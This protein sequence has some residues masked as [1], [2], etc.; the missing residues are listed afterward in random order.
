[1][2]P[3]YQLLI[4][5]LMNAVYGCAQPRKVLVPADWQLNSQRINLPMD[6]IWIDR[7]KGIWSHSHCLYFY[8]NGI[9]CDG[10]S[11]HNLSLEEIYSDTPKYVAEI[12]ANNPSRR[13]DRQFDWGVY[14]VTGDTIIGRRMDWRPFGEW[15]RIVE[16]RWLIKDDQPVTISY[17]AL[18]TT[19]FQRPEKGRLLTFT[20]YRFHKLQEKPDSSVAWF[21]NMAWF[22]SYSTARGSVQ[23]TSGTSE[24]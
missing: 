20:G 24:K 12:I 17:I 7:G 18:P 6:G 23:N 15:W 3:K 11:V 8:A 22:R 9:F 14:T 16:T 10:N 5:I 13:T 21:F 1:M 19:I 4:I 2:T